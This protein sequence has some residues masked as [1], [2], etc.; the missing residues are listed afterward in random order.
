M[1]KLP[2]RAMRFVLPLFLT[3]FMT[4]VVSGVSIIQAIGGQ[5]GWLAAWAK[6]WMS[7]W[8]IAFPVMV[9]VMPF[10]Q[11]LVRLVVD[12]PKV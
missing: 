8:A 3:F 5:P 12:V 10:A 2:A 7:S 6:A 4:C 9:V 11:R 1:R